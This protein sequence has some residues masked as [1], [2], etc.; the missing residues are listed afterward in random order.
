MNKQNDNTDRLKEDVEI[1]AIERQQ[2]MSII[3]TL[4]ISHEDLANRLNIKME[5][6]KQA[7][8]PSR[9]FPKWAR[10]FAIGHEATGWAFER[11]LYGN[12]R[13]PKPKK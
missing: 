2:F 3:Q 12:R 6:Y 9:P 5:S 1:W 4:G 11:L 10:A 13:P 7:L 8:Q